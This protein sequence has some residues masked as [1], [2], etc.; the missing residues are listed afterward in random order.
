MRGSGQ[1]RSIFLTRYHLCLF[2]K[3]VVWLGGLAL[4]MHLRPPVPTELYGFGLRA[5]LVS[6]N[7]K[8]IS[9]TEGE[10][11]YALV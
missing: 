6:N 9:K 3:A 4:N 5:D 11:C 8:L 2:H 1:E 10:H 7:D